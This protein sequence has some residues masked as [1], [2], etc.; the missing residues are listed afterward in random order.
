MSGR[1]ASV[2]ARCCCFG[3]LIFLLVLIPHTVTGLR[4]GS[5]RLARWSMLLDVS[6]PGSTQH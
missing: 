5:S 2:G 4:F 3:P 6:N 1:A